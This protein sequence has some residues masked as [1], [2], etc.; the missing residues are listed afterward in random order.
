MRKLKAGIWTLRR[1]ALMAMHP[2]L[3]VGKGTTVLPGCV[4]SHRGPIIIGESSYLGA[5]CWL[6]GDIRIGHKV[7]C[8]GRVAAVGDDHSFD[9][10]GT[11]MIDAGRPHLRRLTVGNDVWI[12]YGAVLMMGVTIGDGAIVGAYSVVTKDVEP[13]TIV[14]GSP[15]RLLRRR[16]LDADQEAVHRQY[17]DELAG[18]VQKV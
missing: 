8:A 15:A 17:L 10:P 12:G 11:A 6:S 14:A 3:K 5:E 1:H 2:N 7:M 9:I 4:I 13:L 16:F 18:K